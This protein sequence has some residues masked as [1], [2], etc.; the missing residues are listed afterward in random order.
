VNRRYYAR[1]FGPDAVSSKE[2]R[3]RE[4][5]LPA[6]PEKRV[7]DEN[8]R[9][10]SRVDLGRPATYVASSPRGRWFDTHATAWDEEH[11]WVN[12]PGE[13]FFSK[14][15]WAGDHR[16]LV[17]IDCCASMIQIMCMV[18][19]WRDEERAVATASFKDGLVAG[20][21]AVGAADAAEKD[22]FK[23]PTATDPQLR[24]AAGE[25]TFITYGAGLGSRAKE[26]NSDP[27]KYGLGWDTAKNLENLIEHGANINANISLLKRLRDEYLPV[28]RRLANAAVRRDPYAGVTF[29]DPFD[30]ALVRWHAPAR[31]RWRSRIVPARCS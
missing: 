8:G 6:M 3:E 25:L 1:F 5:I 14:D 10:T 22:G 12:D 28:C 23:L 9:P 30:S 15:D 21:K 19:G 26:L 29:R 31:S 4:L 2:D 7:L 20:I 13:E 16:P 24:K 27:D 17:G 18:L 11:V